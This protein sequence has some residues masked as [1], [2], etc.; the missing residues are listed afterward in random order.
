LPPH[1]FHVDPSSVPVAHLKKDAVWTLDAGYHAKASV[2][3]TSEYGTSRA[4][5][6]WLL[7]LALNMKSPTLFDTIDR[8]D[9]EDRV[10]N[11]EDTLAA[12]EKQKLIKEKFDPG[13][14]LIRSAPSGWCGRT[15]TILTTSALASSTAR[16]SIFPA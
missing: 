5:G 3:A 15:T 12:R 7:E 16:T 2:A 8:G 1:L 14:F 4:N 11:Q 6:T 13:C 9:R 10:V